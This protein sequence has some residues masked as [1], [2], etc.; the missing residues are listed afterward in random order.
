[1]MNTEQELD[2]L[3]VWSRETQASIDAAFARLRHLAAKAGDEQR[4]LRHD[5]MNANLEVFTEEEAAKKLKASGKTMRRL[6]GE[7]GRAWP[8]FRVGD[9]VRYTNFDLVEITKLLS[10]RVELR[11][12]KRR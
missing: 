3:I 9:L 7:H 5:A 10:R 4:Q 1:M 11:E 12:Q 8:H 6:R 2:Q